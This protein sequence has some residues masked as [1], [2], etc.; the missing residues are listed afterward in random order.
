MAESQLF[1]DFNLTKSICVLDFKTMN[2]LGADSR[3]LITLFPC[4]FRLE[5]KLASSC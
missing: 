2:I 3:L 1:I 4:P 5:W